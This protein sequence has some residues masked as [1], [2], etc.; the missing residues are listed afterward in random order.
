M[1]EIAVIPGWR[2][3]R[4]KSDPNDRRRSVIPDHYSSAEIGPFSYLPS[5]SGTSRR[6]VSA[7]EV[8]FNL[9]DPAGVFER[10]SVRVFFKDG[11]AA[12]F[13]DVE[14]FID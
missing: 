7:R 4:V 1:R 8:N 5:M 9:V 2:S 11:R 10:H 14:R 12:I 13:P 6:R 3:E